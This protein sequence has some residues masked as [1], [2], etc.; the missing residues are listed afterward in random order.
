MLVIC[1]YFHLGVVLYKVCLYSVLINLNAITTIGN[2][3]TKSV[4]NNTAPVLTT[5]KT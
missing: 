4:N 1:M 2:A 5:G 3:P